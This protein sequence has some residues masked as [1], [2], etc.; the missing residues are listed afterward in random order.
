MV[1]AYYLDSRT[2]ISSEELNKIGVLQ[3]QLNAD[4]YEEE[5]KLAQIR[6][7]RSYKNHDVV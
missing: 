3:W 5:G 2:E 1:H 7:E 6:K 4:N